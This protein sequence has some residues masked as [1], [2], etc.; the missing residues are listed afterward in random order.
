MR[1]SPGTRIESA[2]GYDTKLWSIHPR[3]LDPQALVALWR[4]GLLA[5]HRAL[6]AH[7]CLTGTVDLA[8]MELVWPSLQYLPGYT[9][10]LQRGWSPDNMRPQT[11]QEE[12][13]LIAQDP[14]AFIAGKV[15]READRRPVVLP[16]GTTVPR[17]PGYARWMWDG[18]FCGSIGFRWQPGTAELPAYCL[19][20]IGY[21]VVPWKQRRG[22]ATLALKLL[23][24]E[25]RKERLP[26]VELTTDLDNL[27]SQRVVEANGGQVVE[28]FRK[29]AGYGGAESIRYRIPLV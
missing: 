8:G 19:G 29:P 20:H 21:A 15:D 11:S 13:A 25:V 9:Q 28:R 10:A 23:L 12:L 24:P 2:D 7:W 16:D 4:E 22:Y 17:L 6:G 14:A 1:H 3:Y 18:E 5:W 27:A 26:Y